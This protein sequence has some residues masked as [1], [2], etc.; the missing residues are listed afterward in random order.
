[1]TARRRPE[2]GTEAGNQDG[3]T[4]RHLVAEAAHDGDELAM[5]A[6]ARAGTFIGQALADF[7][8]IFNPSVVVI[9]GGVSKSGSYLLDP[10]HTALKEHVLSHYY[11][12]D[13]E[14]VPAAHG[15]EAGL[16]GA[17]ALVRLLAV[18]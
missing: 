3:R 2:R 5:A 16:L 9:G 15:D 8:H 13:L 7:L 10:M 14:I 18:A 6:L 17:L 4:P 1:M 12:D 11:L